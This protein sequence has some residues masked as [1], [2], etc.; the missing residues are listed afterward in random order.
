MEVVLGIPREASG[1]ITDLA[2]A[3]LCIADWT[4]QKRKV[5][6]TNGCFDILHQ[7]H[8]RYLAQAR[9]L[10][11]A[12]VVGLNSDVSI[13]RIKGDKRPIMTQDERAEVLA[14]LECVDVVV[15][16]MRMIPAL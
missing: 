4:A 8:V 14:S 16:L 15:F 12:L 11:D 7:G 3:A 6:F 2:E 1:K 9:A 13:R 5:V 10:G